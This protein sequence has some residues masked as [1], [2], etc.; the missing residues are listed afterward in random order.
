M[1]KRLRIAAVIS[2]VALATALGTL[3]PTVAKAA[4]PATGTVTTD[5]E[6]TCRNMW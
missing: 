6:A 3:V 5:S 4:N 2:A 1:G